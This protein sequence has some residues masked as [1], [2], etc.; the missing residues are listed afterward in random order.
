[1]PKSGSPDK[2]PTEPCGNQRQSDTPI[3]SRLPAQT[4]PCKPRP[5]A[6]RTRPMERWPSGRRRTPG[7]CVG[8]EPSRGFES[9]PLR[10]LTLKNGSPDPPEAGFSRCFR[11]LCALG[12]SP[13]HAQKGAH[14]FSTGCYSP[15]LMTTLFW[16]SGRKPLIRWKNLSSRK[17]TSMLVTLNQMTLKSKCISSPAKMRSDLVAATQRSLGRAGS[18]RFPQ[19]RSKPSEKL[20]ADIRPAFFLGTIRHCRETA[21]S[22]WQSHDGTSSSPISILMTHDQFY[23]IIRI[24]DRA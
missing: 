9:L 15:N 3:F 14:A 16:C 19:S 5:P 21:V 23:V 18:G 22:P 7:K 20:E 8:G 6:A 24:K 12:C 10:H 4:P 13:A 1:M 2:F 17:L 11:G